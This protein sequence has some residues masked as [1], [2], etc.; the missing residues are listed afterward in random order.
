M[1]GADTE[2]RENDF[3]AW[4]GRLLYEN[5]GVAYFEPRPDIPFFRSDT[6]KLLYAILNVRETHNVEFQSFFALMQQVGEETGIMRVE[7]E[8]QDD[9]VPLTVV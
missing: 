6:I 9:Y 1:C 8:D 7:E 2:T 4:V 5:Q 3:V